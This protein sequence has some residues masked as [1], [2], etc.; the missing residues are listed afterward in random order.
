MLNSLI[1]IV[2]RITI[3]LFIG[4]FLVLCNKLLSIE[5]IHPVWVVIICIAE[6]LYWIFIYYIIDKTIDYENGQKKPRN[7]SKFIDTSDDL[8]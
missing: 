5:N 3:A 6:L 7:Y 8:K 1:K 2:G 4:L